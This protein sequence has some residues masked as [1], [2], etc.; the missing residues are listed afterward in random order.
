MKFEIDEGRPKRQFLKGLFFG[1]IA[2]D[3]V[4][5]AAFEEG[6]YLAEPSRLQLATKQCVK[7]F[8]LLNLLRRGWRRRKARVGLPQ[9]EVSCH[10]DGIGCSLL[11]HSCG[12]AVGWEYSGAPGVL[13]RVAEEVPRRA[14][15]CDGHFIMRQSPMACSFGHWL[16]RS[17]RRIRLRLLRSMPILGGTYVVSSFG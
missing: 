17:S 12:I 7:S 8:L 5:C 10:R 3:E 13:V 15:R 14:R 9:P 16:Q 2:R 4:P 6:V 11:I 1:D